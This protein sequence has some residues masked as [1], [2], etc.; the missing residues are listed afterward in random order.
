M[1]VECGSLDDAIHAFEVVGVKN[2][3]LWSVILNGLCCYGC[4]EEVL[5]IF[6]DFN[7]TYLSVDGFILT[8]VLR[9]CD[10]LRNLKVGSEVH[11]LVYR[12]GY[13]S[14]LF[15]EQLFD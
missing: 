7:H 6:N 3:R 9:A 13:E 5:R 10:S 4:F 15:C 1:L 8:S 12:R 14:N 2:L 11:G